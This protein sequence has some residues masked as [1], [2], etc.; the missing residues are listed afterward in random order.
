MCKQHLLATSLLVILSGCASEP[1][2]QG[3]ANILNSP[4]ATL[5]NVIFLYFALQPSLIPIKRLLLQSLTNNYYEATISKGEA[6]NSAVKHW[7]KAKGYSN[8]A[9]SLSDNNRA[10]L[11]SPSTGELIFS[12]SLKQTLV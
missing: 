5:L 3:V 1:E 4:I 6:Y 10:I 11:S 12:G 9:W 2:Y 7:L 8:I